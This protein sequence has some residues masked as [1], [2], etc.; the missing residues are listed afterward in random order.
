MKAS[1]SRSRI[2]GS[3]AAPPSKSYTI[4]G[5]MCAAL[6]KGKSRIVSPLGS[7][8][9]EAATRVLRQVGTSIRRSE[10]SW[11]VTGNE[12][13]VPD[14]ELFCGDSAATFR[15]MTAL[16]SIIPGTCRL[17]AGASLGRRP[18]GP[19]V[20]ALQQLG[21]HCSSTGNL[22][23][24]TVIGG[25][26]AGGIVSLPGDVS[27]QYVSALLLLAPFARD[28]LTVRLTTPLESRPYVMMT[29]DTMQWFDVTVAFND[30][31]DEFTVEPQKYE[32]ATY[33]IEG[34]WSSASYL[35]ALGA[36]A[37]RVE[38]T[39]LPTETMQ[40]DRMLLQ[41]LSEMGAGIT[42]NNNSVIVSQSRLKSI[43]TDLTDCI[44]L[45]PT[46]AA[47]AATAEGTSIFTGIA[48]AR[49]KESDRVAAVREGL[50]RLGIKTTEDTDTL[51]VTGGKFAGAQIDSHND[52]RIAMAFSM[53]GVL[54]GG[55]SIDNAECVAKT[56]PEYWDVL[57]MLG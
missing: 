11:S 17:T 23:P 36:L 4:R 1:I 42:V 37:G 15:F 19:L 55:M 30:S 18:V 44:D 27:S 39:E 14:K 21:V 57:K 56:Y 33:T 50:A 48:R 20:Q 53:L 43:K 7:E 47:L 51:T 38:V 28:T 8:D 35:L 34:D 13:K 12:F 54:S 25:K 16:C 6:A 2:E 46:M 10:N 22:P 41:F 24:V 26:L 9:T 29:L 52:H 31:L 32:P 5:L 45:L 3:V 40:G 49:V